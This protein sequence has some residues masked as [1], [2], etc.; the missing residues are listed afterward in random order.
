MNAP[1]RLQRRHDGLKEVILNSKQMCAILGICIMLLCM[2]RA[3]TR[4]LLT[5]Q[6]PIL[7]NPPSSW[8]QLDTYQPDRDLLQTG[9]F[10][11]IQAYKSLCC[12]WARS[13]MAAEFSL[14]YDKNKGQKLLLWNGKL[15]CSICR[16]VCTS[17][18]V[19]TFVFGDLAW[20]LLE[21]CRVR[22][23]ERSFT[24]CFS[25]GERSLRRSVRGRESVCVTVVTPREIERGHKP[26]WRLLLEKGK[27]R[28]KKK[29]FR[30]LNNWG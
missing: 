8:H 15:Q 28:S 21:R 24:S 12:P 27:R 3:L 13:S 22:G 29:P 20:L 1:G 9:L 25:L 11:V 14:C 19:L 30:V 5:L 17:S 23:E 18:S 16:E 7:L 10:K 2:H 4:C 6:I 26:V